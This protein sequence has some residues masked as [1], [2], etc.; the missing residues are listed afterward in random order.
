MKFLPI[1]PSGNESSERESN[2][3]L[4]LLYLYLS[5]PAYLVILTAPN[6]KS[7]NAKSPF[8]SRDHVSNS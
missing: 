3:I 2:P 4:W 6:K 8:K 7:S 1:L 5:G